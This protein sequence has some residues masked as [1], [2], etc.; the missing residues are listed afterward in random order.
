[1]ILFLQRF[2]GVYVHVTKQ[3][4]PSPPLSETRV[5]PKRL[6]EHSTGRKA[7]FEPE[8]S[9][10]TFGCSA[11]AEDSEVGPSSSFVLD[12]LGDAKVCQGE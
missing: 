5:S 6:A 4:Q 1:M 7:S 2:G 11:E 12:P 8:T 9:N 3:M 10:E